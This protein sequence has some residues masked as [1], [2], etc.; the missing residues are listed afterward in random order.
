MYHHGEKLNSGSPIWLRNFKYMTSLFKYLETRNKKGIALSNEWWRAIQK[1]CKHIEKVQPMI[2][3][4]FRPHGSLCQLDKHSCEHAVKT[5]LVHIHVPSNNQ[6]FCWGRNISLHHFQ[7]IH[8]HIPLTDKSFLEIG[9]FCISINLE[10][11]QWRWLYLKLLVHN[12][13]NFLIVSTI[14]PET[15]SVVIGKSYPF[16]SPLFLPSV[17]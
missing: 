7:N 4:I 11:S 3:K 10:K 14:F 16:F 12:V 2:N 1:D 6:G 5:V 8:V 9:M 15:S 13:L 17:L